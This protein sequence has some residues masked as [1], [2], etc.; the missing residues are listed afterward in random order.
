MR[1]KIRSIFI[2]LFATVFV[3]MTPFAQ[4]ENGKEFVA[5][6]D[7]GETKTIMVG[8]KGL[9]LDKTE[10]EYK[11]SPLDD[12]LRKNLEEFEN[13][14][15]EN[16][17]FDI[18]KILANLM[19]TFTAS[20]LEF[21][22]KQVSS[23]DDCGSGEDVE[24]DI[25][26]ER[27][28]GDEEEK[29]EHDPLE[30][31][32]E[33][34]KDDENIL[35]IKDKAEKGA[36]TY[37][38]YIAYDRLVRFTNTHECSFGAMDGTFMKIN[39]EL[40]SNAY[41]EIIGTGIYKDSIP[42]EYDG[43]VDVKKQ[44]ESKIKNSA[45]KIK[46]NDKTVYFER[47]CLTHVE[48]GS[49][50]SATSIRELGGS[51]YAGDHIF[52]EF[53]FYNPIAGGLKKEC[54]KLIEEDSEIIDRAR[55]YRTVFHL[56]RVE[57]HNK[58]VNEMKEAIKQVSQKE[59]YLL[60]GYEDNEDLH[61]SDKELLE[62]LKKE[63]EGD[64]DVPSSFKFG[65]MNQLN[66]F[67]VLVNITNIPTLMYLTNIV[68]S[69]AMILLVF[70]LL[71]KAYSLMRGTDPSINETSVA[72]YVIKFGAVM[73]A[74]YYAPAILQDILSLNN[75]LVNTLGSQE[76]PLEITIGDK[77]ETYDFP[78][79][80]SVIGMLGVFLSL[81]L[82]TIVG[83][84][85]TNAAT[86][87]LFLTPGIGLII[88]LLSL[89]VMVIVFIPIIKLVIWWYTRLFKLFVFTVLSP[90]MFMMFA[91]PG[92]AK[93][94]SRFVT[95]FVRTSFEQFF[96]LLGLAALLVFFAELPNMAEELSF[97]FV[98]MGIALY[99]GLTFVS[100]I[101]DVAGGMF[102]G[103]A[104]FS[105]AGAFAGMA[106]LASAI[107]KDRRDKSNRSSE[108]EGESERSQKDEE[109]IKENLNTGRSGDPSE[110]V[111][112]V[113]EDG[114][115]SEVFGKVN[116]EPKGLDARP[117]SSDFN[118]DQIFRDSS[119]DEFLATDGEG[120]VIY[121]SNT[122]IEGVDDKSN[123]ELSSFVSTINKDGKDLTADD[124]GQMMI[125]LSGKNKDLDP[126]WV[127]ELSPTAQETLTKG[128]DSAIKEY[129]N[130]KE[131][132]PSS[133]TENESFFFNKMNEIGRGGDG[134]GQGHSESTE[135]TQQRMT[136]TGVVAG[137]G[138]ESG[139]NKVE[140][141]SESDEEVSEELDDD[142][143][144]QENFD[145]VNTG[146]EEVSVPDVEDEEDFDVVNT[147][148][149]EVSVPDI[150]DE[151]GEVII[152][153]DTKETV[154]TTNNIDD[155]NN[156]EDGEGEMDEVIVT[157]NDEIES[158]EIDEDV[159]D[160]DEDEDEEFSDPERIDLD[161]KELNVDQ[162][163]ETGYE[164]YYPAD[165]TEK[166]RKHITTMGEQK[167]ETYE[168][169]SR[170]VVKN[171]NRYETDEEVMF[172][173]D[174]ESEY[175]VEDK[176]TGNVSVHKLNEPKFDQEGKLKP[177]RKIS[178][179]DVIDKDV[180]VIKNNS[181]GEE[182]SVK[183]SPDKSDVSSGSG[184]AEKNSA[185]EGHSSESGRVNKNSAQ[186]NDSSNEENSERPKKKIYKT[187]PVNDSR[188]EVKDDIAPA[189]DISE[190]ESR[191][192]NENPDD[193]FDE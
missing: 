106:G 15:E 44:L 62:E 186:E 52:G 123:K 54:E 35:E 168:T 174:G 166:D 78:I 136:S 187:P 27:E 80:I 50:G 57:S 73:A 86:A 176:K 31:E 149:E 126:H 132:D 60:S 17:G 104:N 141:N 93:I 51:G 120:N 45:S 147:E 58:K 34:E 130:L 148:N 1:I 91:A 102:D 167:P 11:C 159:E 16:S 48:S 24:Y 69:M 113:D 77:I 97:G 22:A 88:L 99:A 139:E 118:E 18:G 119:G 61:E 193:I 20:T 42:M 178:K 142:Y 122:G 128:R 105:G 28:D 29:E 55:K 70:F 133:M 46:E 26:E 10:G 64:G 53:S 9:L 107:T 101:P 3:A 95:N 140:I 36:S 103:D 129:E 127:D 87:I 85:G 188:S 154:D 14:E 8:S 170:Q 153:E 135:E 4:S 39:T 12:K 21:F 171:T 162:K 115:K 169:K 124:F 81:M 33:V 190:K 74:I 183:E 177:G 32:G 151:D 192:K 152:I 164:D 37:E 191:P 175:T 84:A 165:A 25:K 40:C 38:D 137:I 63:Y 41:S 173:N 182:H 67:N 184:Q 65:L 59:L 121:N 49:M 160:E 108:S 7:E 98:G 189:K 100:Q 92:T 163:V 157:P 111:H 145:V 47:F 110:N 13:E 82:D 172:R 6:A 125:A 96:V 161:K 30:L 66:V 134:Q 155:E 117:T 146:N 131:K 156:L 158:P 79:R 43:M 5:L 150:E 23:I 89:A 179:N 144:D 83:V 112:D 90:L 56:N 19:F 75:I 116:E 68:Q 94:A 114:Y 71:Y 181:E 138:G 76:I 109:E 185:Q 72:S 143:E 180:E 2:I